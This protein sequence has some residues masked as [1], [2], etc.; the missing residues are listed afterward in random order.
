MSKL[1]KF[2]FKSI[3][4]RLIFSCVVSAIA[5]YG[6][7]YWHARQLLKSTLD[8]WVLGFAQS[9]VNEIAHELDS[10]LLAIEKQALNLTRSLQALTANFNPNSQNNLEPQLQVALD[11]L[12]AQP[13]V[14]AIALVDIPQNITDTASKGWQYSRQAQFRN[15]DQNLATNWL[16][17]CQSDRLLNNSLNYQVKHQA[18]WTKPYSLNN[19]SAQFSTTYCI[20]LTQATNPATTRIFAI[21]IDLDWL[22]AMLNQQ[23]SVQ[24]DKAS[25]ET[26]ELEVSEPFAIAPLA[27]PDQQWLVKPNNSELFKSLQSSQQALVNHI[28]DSPIQRSQISINNFQNKVI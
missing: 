3:T 18:F 23:P 16:A 11:Q 20:V 15:L 24:S 2:Q 25:D 13:Q 10:K 12:F 17:R 19:S 1:L 14:Q 7:S 4:H 9:R 28:N 22:K 6:I 21:A 5:I 27:A 26:S 8:N